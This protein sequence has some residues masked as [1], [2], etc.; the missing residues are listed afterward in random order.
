M[1][2]PRWEYWNALIFPS[3]GTSQLRIEPSSLALAGRFFT[4]EPPG[5]LLISYG[6]VYLYIYII[7][8]SEAQPHTLGS[9]SNSFVNQAMKRK[10][11]AVV[12]SEARI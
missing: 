2:F 4:T 7:V 10:E 11:P 6:T 12:V 8:L 1:A 9:A 3:R 5:R